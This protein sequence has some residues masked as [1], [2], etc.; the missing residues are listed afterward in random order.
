MDRLPTPNGEDDTVELLPNQ[1][2]S[3]N[4]AS[5]LIKVDLAALTHR[6]RVRAE[7]EDHYLAVR[8]NR[9][10]ETLFTNVGESLLEPRFEETGYGLLV[11]DGIGGAVGGEIASRT[12][13][14]KL[15][16]LVVNTPDWIMKIGRGDE[17]AILQRRM[18][19][20]FRQID[21]TLR[22]QAKN[23]QSL[24]GMG[25]TLTVAMNLGSDAFIGHIGDSRAYLLRGSKLYQLTRDH[26]MAQ[27]M[28]DAGITNPQDAVTR[29]MRHVLTA[30]LGSTG[31]QVDPQV[32]RLR[33]TTGDQILLCTDGLT[34]MVS[35]DIIAS[36]LREA[37]TASDACHK[38]IDLALSA[39]GSDNVT[40]V[41]ARYQFPAITSTAAPARRKRRPTDLEAF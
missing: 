31:E 35:E 2:G 8:F 14:C 40:V 24:A 12:A 21:E 17:P 26:T 20:R 5:S 6:G 38:L 19:Q 4:P 13:L 11:A 36:V 18:T 3:A 1:T 29:A 27:A 30:A 41:L 22:K 25:T 39:G 34:E 37:N 15:V 7:N 10:L 9:S 33:I 28:I 32:Q 23:D 16:E